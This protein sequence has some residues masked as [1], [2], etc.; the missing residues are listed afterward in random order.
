MLVGVRVLACIR[1]VGRPLFVV[2]FGY[3]GRLLVR[4]DGVGD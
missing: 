3:G 4:R 2:L 1:R